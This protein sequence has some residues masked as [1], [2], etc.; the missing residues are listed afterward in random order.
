MGRKRE[1]EAERERTR[2][3]EKE[4]EEKRLEEERKRNE[5]EEKRKKKEAEAKPTSRWGSQSKTNST[6]EPVQEKPKPK[7]GSAAAVDEVPK[8]KPWEKPSAAAKSTLPS[9]NESAPKNKVTFNEKTSVSRKTSESDSDSVSISNKTKTNYSDS[10]DHDSGIKS[11]LEAIKN[12]LRA[13]KSRNEVLEHMQSEALK[14]T[15]LTLES[16]KASEATAELIKAREKIRELDNSLSA[17]SKEKKA[18]SLKIKEIESTL[19]RRPQV[20]ETQK[21]ITEL[22]TKLKFV[23][24]KCEDMTREND[25]LR[26]NVQNLE[27]ELEEVQDNFREDEADEYRTLKRE[28]ENSAKNCRVLQFKLK[29]T[30]KSLADIT[31]D[32]NELETKVKTM[33]GGSGALD[34]MNKVRQLEKDLEAKTMQIGR[35]EAEI[36]SNKPASGPRKGG[37]GP[38]LSRTGSVERNVEDQLL[39]D[40]QDSIER[41]NDLKEQL[42]MAEEEAAET[43]KKLSRL[44]DDNESL[45]GQVKRMA[46]KNKGT[47]RSPSPYNRNAVPEKD[48]VSENGEDL[49]PAELKVQLEVS[50][51]E[52]EVL[53]KKVENLLTENLKITKE[54]KEITSKLNEAK[55]APATRSYGMPARDNSSTNEKKIEELQTEV[56]TFRVK[57]IEKDRELERL[58]AQVKASKTSGKTLKRTGSQDEDLLKKL[59][60]IE[61]EAEV[62]RTKTQ[63]LESENENLKSSKKTPAGNQ[64]K[65]ALEEKVRGLEAK[66]KEANKKVTE[67]EDSSKGTMKTS[68][69]LDRI[70]RERSS[71]ESEIIKLKDTASAEKRKVEKTERELAAVTDKSE[72]AQREVIAAEREKRRI[73]EEKN[74]LDSQVSRLEGDLRSVTREKERYKEE[75]ESARLKN[76]E[77]LSQTQEGMKAFKDQIDA[78]KQELSDE[79]RSGR[80]L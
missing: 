61:K 24:R 69:G 29:K 27:V 31:S 38:C 79:K 23:E 40:L 51:Q 22:Q 13:V 20:S 5:E 55:K 33:S 63:Q 10:S 26:G 25:D 12:E 66:L 19:E 15:P 76:R 21:T 7:W 47:R 64:D 70:K 28:L 4:R 11:E 6:P 3:R 34:N 73:E 74:K 45:S 14:K 39:K 67:L 48:E 30:E 54:V 41:E 32:H 68:L 1:E 58:D 43:R 36:K 57:T 2:K 37:P 17:A 53:R 72:K 77:N 44:E 8:R 60:V 59:S 49:S 78:L 52:T 62:L 42:N 35:L 80:D 56:N 46:T 18:F 50:E 65:Y 75:S 71:L 16:A 9:L